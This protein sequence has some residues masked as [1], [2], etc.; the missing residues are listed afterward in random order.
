MVFTKYAS[1]YQAG[2]VGTGGGASYSGVTNITLDHIEVSLCHGYGIRAGWSSSTVSNSY[3]YNNG[4]MG[5][6]GGNTWGLSVFNNELSYNNYAHFACGNECGGIK[7]GT[8]S[9]SQIV[10]NHVHHNIGGIA[11]NNDSTPSSD[12]GGYGIRCDVDCNN[13]DVSYNLIHD[14]HGPGMQIE[15]SCS[16]SVT[17]NR[18]YQDNTTNTSQQ[19]WAGEILL[20]ASHH[21]EVSWNVLGGP[22]GIKMPYQ[23]RTDTGTNCGNPHPVGYTYIHDNQITCSAPQ[24]TGSSCLGGQNDG[25]TLGSNAFSTDVFWNN[26]YNIQSCCGNTDFS[27]FTSYNGTVGDGNVQVTFSTW[28]GYQ[29]KLA[30]PANAT[31]V[32]LP[33]APAY[34]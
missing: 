16:M 14:H 6:G 26:H 23:N 1:N 15:E 10:G 4:E 27:W 32:N 12:D 29:D 24:G 25:G 8:Q 7:L 9:G 34:Q 3:V 18:M 20:P 22:Y 13:V 2:C 30:P 19:E 17:H 5:I 11:G 33:Q 31:A 21:L 28:Q